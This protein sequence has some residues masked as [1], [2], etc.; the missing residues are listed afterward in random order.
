MV[1]DGDNPDATVLVY[2]SRGYDDG[3]DKR[4]FSP[5]QRRN[6][7][8]RK[9]ALPDGSFPIVNA[10]D[11]RN[12][13][14][15]FGRAKS[16][17]AARAHI[18]RRAKAL[19]ATGILPDD[20]NVSKM[21]GSAESASGKGAGMPLDVSAVEDE[22]LRKSIEDAVTE[23]ESTITEHES[24]IAEL[25]KEPDPDPVEDADPQVQALLKAQKEELA[26]VSDDLAKE[27]KARRTAEFIQKAEPLGILLGKAEEVGP[28]LEELEGAA[29]EAYT[30]IEGMLNAA[31]SRTELADILKEFGAGEGEGDNDPIAQRETFVKDFITDYLK[32]HSEASREEAEVYGNAAFW[33]A[34]PEAK[35]EA[36]S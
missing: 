4:A 6:L 33:K 12:A 26:K 34:H 27:R 20:W 28:V 35:K 25:S 24:T 29:P 30:K 15:A 18:I 32:E 3:F 22:E 16:K 14:S 21:T 8:E 13:V 2:K 36:R 31:L 17:T 23:Y 5:E 1:A 9:L 10:G 11:L 19:G 7:A